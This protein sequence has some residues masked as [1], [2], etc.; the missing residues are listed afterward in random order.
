MLLIYFISLKYFAVVSKAMTSELLNYEEW[1]DL[2]P[3]PQN[4]GPNPVVAIAYTNE[5]DLTLHYS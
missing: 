3:I 5:C 1:V 4:D 2:D